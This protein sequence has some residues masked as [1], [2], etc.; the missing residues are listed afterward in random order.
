MTRSTPMKLASLMAATLLG[1]SACGAT[2]SGG[3]SG[4]DSDAEASDRDWTACQPGSEAED[5]DSLDPDDDKTV[6]FAVFNGWDETYASVHVLK[7]LLER[8]GY[9][10]NIK[11]L[12]AGPAYQAVAKGD[13]DFHTDL[14]MPTTHSA[15]F[16]QVKDDIDVQGCWYGAAQ[17]TIA[18]NEDSPA[19]S[20]SDLKDMAD[21]YDNTL[22]GIEAGAGLTKATKENV[23]PDYGLEQLEYKISSTPAMLAQVK[24]STDAGDNVAVTLWHPHWAY[25]K[26]PM[27]DLRDPENSLGEKEILYNVGN[28]ESVE[29]FPY[30]AQ[31]VKNLAMSEDTLADLEALMFSE[32]EYDGDNPEK[33]VAEWLDDNPDFVEDFRAGELEG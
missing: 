10:I 1:L 31:A 22:Y 30:V 6:H 5:L 17:N 14:M 2:N 8:D 25:S 15:Y 19:Q 11:E 13:V 16:D 29:K 12:E 21:E 24:K 18:V 7:N 23:I 33:A 9:T 27:R 32:D 4:G 3:G 20:I 26:F 28:K